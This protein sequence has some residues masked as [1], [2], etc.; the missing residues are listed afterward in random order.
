M[1]RKAIYITASGELEIVYREG[2]AIPAAQGMTGRTIVDVPV[3][4]PDELSWNA[5]AK[6]FVQDLTSVDAVLLAA[7]DTQRE[8]LQMTV[9][10][11]G[12]AKKYVY[13]R[14]AAEAIAASGIVATVLNALTLVDKKRKYPFAYAESAL[15]GDALSAVLAR[16]E[17]GMNT[18][19]I[20]NAR[21]EAVA[22]KAKRDIKAATTVAA[23]RAAYAAINWAWSA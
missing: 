18:S 13:N 1:T 21:I 11:P 17:A 6:G 2:E 12:G 19:A 20:E 22:Q 10:T 8:T 15:T 5:T 9:L 3:G 16:F 4:Y 14:K 7:V 23:K